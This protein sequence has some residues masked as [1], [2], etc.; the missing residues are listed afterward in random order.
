MLLE[1]KKSSIENSIWT[2]DSL[3]ARFLCTVPVTFESNCYLEIKKKESKY[4]E[5]S[6]PGDVEGRP[7]RAQVAFHTEKSF[8]YF[9]SPA[10]RCNMAWWMPIIRLYDVENVVLHEAMF[11]QEHPTSP[12]DFRPKR[13]QKKKVS[14]DR[15][16][17]ELPC[18]NK[19]N[20]KTR[21]KAKRRKSL[22]QH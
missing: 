21:R 17:L 3:V 8:I 22:V 2:V 15:S 6:L 1:N 16:I 5:N 20:I 7:K 12:A 14:V 11:I 4:V 10:I 18:D 19:D 9:L 13:H